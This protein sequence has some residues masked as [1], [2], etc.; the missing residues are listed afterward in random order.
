MTEAMPAGSK[1]E[2]ISDSGNTS[3]IM[4]QLRRRKNIGWATA[5]REERNKNM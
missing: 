2:P 1:A 4:T 5:A 3:E